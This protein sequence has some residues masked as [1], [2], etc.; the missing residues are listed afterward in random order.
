MLKPTKIYVKPILEILRKIRPSGLAHITGGGFSKL[1]RLVKARNLGFKID[2]IPKPLPIFTL[3]QDEG[4]ISN[5]E[6]YRTFNMGI[7]FC[8]IA[9]SVDSE[10]IQKIFKQHRINSTKIGEIIKDPGVFIGELKID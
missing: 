7:G 9:S 4:K 3:I 6:M 8:I 10:K 2:N 1:T 5:L